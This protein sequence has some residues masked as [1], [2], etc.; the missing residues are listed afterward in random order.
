MAPSPVAECELR[1]SLRAAR[2]EQSKLSDSRPS[3][4]ACCGLGQP[5]EAKRKE[6]LSDLAARI[7]ELEAKLGHLLAE[8]Q[9]S[10]GHAFVAFQLEADRNKLYERLGADSRRPRFLRSAASSSGYDVRAAIGP[11]PSNV[12]WEN[13]EL[14]D[15][16]RRSNPL[17]TTPPPSCSLLVGC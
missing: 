2:E 7:Q 17:P 10:S 1:E 15:S 13:L 14:R 9:R 12:C 16:V 6:H 4:W 5:S 3:R 11:E 8:P